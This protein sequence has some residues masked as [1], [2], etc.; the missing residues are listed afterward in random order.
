MN[1]EVRKILD[2]YA[3][4]LVII[5]CAASFF[6]GIVSV[7]E[8]TGYNMNMTV[9]GTVETQ[10]QE[11]GFV[12]LYGENGGFFIPDNINDLVKE[13]KNTIQERINYIF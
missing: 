12:V 13:L 1:L 2:Q 6:L 5:L 3:F 11:D 7:R 9:Y 8:K 4:S 10:K